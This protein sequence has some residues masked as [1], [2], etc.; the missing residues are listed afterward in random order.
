MKL[1]MDDFTDLCIYRIAFGLAGAQVDAA[2]IS[3][4]AGRHVPGGKAELLAKGPYKNNFHA[5]W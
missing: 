5:F 1:D 2:T 3:T 4:F